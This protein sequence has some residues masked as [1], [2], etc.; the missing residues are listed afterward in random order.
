MRN[1]VLLWTLASLATASPASADVGASL[2]LGYVRSRVAVTDATALD[3][4]LVRFAI[5][6]SPNSRFHYGAEAEEGSLSGTTTLPNG[7]VARTVPGTTTTGGSTT[8]PVGP[9]SPLGGNTLGLKVFAGIHSNSGPV[10]IG[11]DVALGRR[12]TWVESDLGNDV[13]G[14]KYEPLMELRTR[15]D[16][17]LS[18]TATVGVSAASDL[19]DRRNVSLAFLFALNFDRR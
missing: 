8:S 10:R 11:A 17:W 2:D 16:F 5:R 12:D 3:A 7:A 1:A 9:E 4:D 13:A 18:T 14:R 6:L 15:A 19:L